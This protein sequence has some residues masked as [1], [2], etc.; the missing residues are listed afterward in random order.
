MTANHIR[1]YRQNVLVLLH[2]QVSAR[3]RTGAAEA[4]GGDGERRFSF[5]RMER[6]RSAAASCRRA[7]PITLA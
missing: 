7:Q 2:V 3:A 1:N 6:H 4:G 5:G